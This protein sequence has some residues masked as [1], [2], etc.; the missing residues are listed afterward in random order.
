MEKSTPCAISSDVVTGLG[1]SFGLGSFRGAM[2]ARVG[3][4]GNRK[5]GDFI[6]LATSCATKAGFSLRGAHKSSPASALWRTF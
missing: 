2:D 5:L 4:R 1:L 3:M 6:C